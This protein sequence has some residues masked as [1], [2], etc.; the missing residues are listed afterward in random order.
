MEWWLKATPEMASNISANIG[1]ARLG[2]PEAHGPE[3]LV[4]LQ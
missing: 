2:N 1:G 4:L 3:L